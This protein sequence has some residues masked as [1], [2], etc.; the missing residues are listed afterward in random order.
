MKTTTLA[1]P[2]TLLAALFLALSFAFACGADDGDSATPISL[3][4]Y[5]TSVEEIFDDAEEATDVAEESLNEVPRDAPLEEQIDAIDTFL[6]DIDGVFTDAAERLEALVAPDIV[7]DEN[8]DFIDGVRASLSLGNALRDDL[9]DI[10]TQDE[11]DDRLSD[12]GDDVEASVT[13]SDNACFDLHEIAD[14]EGIT[15]DLCED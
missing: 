2:L 9:P 7:A 13:K 8:Q 4:Q 1:R 3:D 12:Y 6:S 5:F 15:I 10:E 14:A 11:L